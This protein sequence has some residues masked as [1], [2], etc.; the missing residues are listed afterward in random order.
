MLNTGL[1]L[2]RP[3]ESQ[4]NAYRRFLIANQ[5][6]SVGSLRDELRKAVDDRPYSKTDTDD[7]AATYERAY[8]DV[9]KIPYSTPAKILF[10]TCKR[11]C[12]ECEQ[13]CYH[14]YLYQYPWFAVCPIHRRALTMRCP[15]CG[16]LWPKPSELPHRD[17]LRCGIRFPVK[18]LAT[19]NALAPLPNFDVL[20]ALANA[21]TTYQAEQHPLLFG[22]GARAKEFGVHYNVPVSSIYWPSLAF[23]FDSSWKQT[24]ELIGA[25]IIEVVKQTFDGSRRTP[26]KYRA[27]SKLPR[28]EEV[29]LS[30]GII[31]RIEGQ[32]RALIDQIAP[33]E[34]ALKARIEGISLGELR[35]LSQRQLL[36]E[37]LKTWRALAWARRPTHHLPNV[38]Y[39]KIP[40]CNDV[41]P[42]PVMM[43]GI[44]EDRSNRYGGNAFNIPRDL[45]IWLYRAD[46]WRSFL[47]IAVF[48]YTFRVPLLQD[49]R[50]WNDFY[51]LLPDVAQPG[52][53]SQ[54]QIRISMTDPGEVS[55]VLPA[56]YAK[57]E[58]E[59][60]YRQITT[61]NL[62]PFRNPSI[63]DDEKA[64]VWA[65]LSA[66]ALAKQ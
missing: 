66:G 8:C 54:R 17:C 51:D 30:R 62:N 50:S 37:S 24:C 18:R 9:H 20:T 29:R 57:I 65:A 43:S 6:R 7:L 25:P 42:R 2:R 64:I 14:C 45:K 1:L 53:W 31:S 19:L 38:V 63:S 47:A 16:Q 40:G 13:I 22:E 59:S 60:L 56:D 26:Y 44:A 49:N 12:P 35:G 28:K 52:A 11:N 32:I 4:V 10:G 48:L 5:S 46:L 3:F 15:D 34:E 55:V 36:L 39:F 33:S 23:P 27:P 21:V 41:P 58:V 61:R